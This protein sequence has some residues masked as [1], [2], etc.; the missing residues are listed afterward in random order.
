MWLIDWHYKISFFLNFHKKP[1]SNKRKHK[2]E[3]YSHLKFTLILI[4]FSIFQIDLKKKKKN[5]VT[6]IKANFKI[7]LK[8]QINF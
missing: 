8:L 4:F 1:L 7:S 6:N 3:K 5:L 2:N